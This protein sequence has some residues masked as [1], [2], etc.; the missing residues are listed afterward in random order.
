MSQSV[1]SGHA[2]SGRSIE[3][4]SLEQGKNVENAKA[5]AMAIQM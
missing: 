2:P 5:C 1:G 3:K 4:S